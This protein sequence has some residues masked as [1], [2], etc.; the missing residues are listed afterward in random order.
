M[1]A[2]IVA[3]VRPKLD[4]VRPGIQCPDELSQSFKSNAYGAF[5]KTLLAE[6]NSKGAREKS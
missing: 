3:G 1:K 5:S 4:R 2:N 6:K